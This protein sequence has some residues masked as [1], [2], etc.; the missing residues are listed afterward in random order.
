MAVRRRG[1]IKMNKEQELL[2]HLSNQQP[3][4]VVCD[5]EGNVEELEK[6]VVPQFVADWYEHHKDSLSKDIIEFIIDYTDN[7]YEDKIAGALACWFCNNE[8]DVIE[9][10]VKMKIYGYQ[11]EGA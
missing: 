9:T 10:L 8:D 7:V 11:V 4:V 6:A 2:K 3:F 5:R 1:E